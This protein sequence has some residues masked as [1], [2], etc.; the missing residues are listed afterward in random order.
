MYH[1]AY[2]ILKIYLKKKILESPF[3]SICK[4]TDWDARFEKLDIFP[5]GLFVY[6]N[7]EFSSLIKFEILQMTGSREF[8]ILILNWHFKF[9]V[10]I[11]AT[12]R[13]VRV[14]GSSHD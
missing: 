1:L 14:S 6:R 4:S 9:Q 13:I 7:L 2:K 3:S 5:I 12:L 10:L 8:Q 11:I